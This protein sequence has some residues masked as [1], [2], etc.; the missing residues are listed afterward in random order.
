MSSEAPSQSR[1]RLPRRIEHR[2]KINAVA[3]KLAQRTPQ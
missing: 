2:R 1:D 3:A